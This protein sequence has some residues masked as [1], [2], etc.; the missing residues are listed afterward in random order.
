MH[1][2]RCRRVCWL[3]KYLRSLSNSQ[4]WNI[5]WKCALFNNQT[6]HYCVKVNLIRDWSFVWIKAC[7]FKV[8]LEPRSWLRPHYLEAGCFRTWFSKITNYFSLVVVEWCTAFD[9]K[10]CKCISVWEFWWW[11]F[12]CRKSIWLY[13]F[14]D[15]T[16]K[17]SIRI[18]A[19]TW[20]YQRTS[21]MLVMNLE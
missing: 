12:I 15:C 5:N 20:N 14:E 3:V 9:V 1:S 7:G 21:C 18:V 11:L 13:Q 8:D 4:S 19:S 2:D 17:E 16:F 6:S 10:V